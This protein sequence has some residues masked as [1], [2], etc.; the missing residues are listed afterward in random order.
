MQSQSNNSKQNK[1]HKGGSSVC[2][3]EVLMLSGVGR[4]VS[5]GD[6]CRDLGAMGMFVVSTIVTNRG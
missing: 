4:L 5:Q 6:N 1:S 3:F 2:V